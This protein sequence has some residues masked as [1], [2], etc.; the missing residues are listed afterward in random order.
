MI[1]LYETNCFGH[2]RLIDAANRTDPEAWAATLSLSKIGEM[3]IQ[4]GASDNV[5]IKNL[6]RI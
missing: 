5:Q 2:D 1:L 6:H 4:S 3:I